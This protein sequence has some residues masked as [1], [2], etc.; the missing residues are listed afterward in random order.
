MDKSKQ[1][2]VQ[3]VTDNKLDDD[4]VRGLWA[5]AIKRL[6]AQAKPYFTLYELADKHVDDFRAAQ[7]A[8]VAVKQAAKVAEI[9]YSL[10]INFNE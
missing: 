1:H 4:Q 2:A 5:Y 7:A 8:K 6:R 9:D 3:R 10:H